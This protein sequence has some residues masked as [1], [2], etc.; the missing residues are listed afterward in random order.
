MELKFDDKVPIYIQVM[1]LI[2]LDIVT[3]KL[4]GGDKLPSVRELSAS[5]K[6]NPNT[7]QRTY[8]EL[9][10]EGITY[11]QRGMG[12]F[13]SED[14]ELIIKLKKEMA[15]ETISSFLEGMKNLGFTAKEILEIIEEKTKGDG[16]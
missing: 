1:N 8:Q 16:C 7:I 14:E 15:E 12:T 3:K 6:V 10:R 13:V 4:L 9:E 11:T 5:L 2:K